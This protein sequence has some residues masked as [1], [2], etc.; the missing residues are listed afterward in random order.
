MAED[1]SFDVQALKHLRRMKE[2][3]PCCPNCNNFSW[4]VGPGPVLLTD[5]RVATTGEYCGLDPEKRLPPP[6]IIAFGCP[7]FTPGVPF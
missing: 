2:L 5:G 4:K 1:F 6:R 3:L 7:A